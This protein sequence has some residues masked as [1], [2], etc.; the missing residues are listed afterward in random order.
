MNNVRTKRIH[1]VGYSFR[2]YSNICSNF[3]GVKHQYFTNKLNFFPNHINKVID[4]LKIFL[5]GP[6]L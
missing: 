6:M 4:T 3:E 2:G 1:L 5:K